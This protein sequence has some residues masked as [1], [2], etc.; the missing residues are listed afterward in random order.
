MQILLD[1]NDYL[2]S[3]YD[4]YRYHLVAKPCNACIITS[5]KQATMLQRYNAW[6]V[7]FMQFKKKKRYIFGHVQVG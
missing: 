5:K 3:K 2:I 1:K 4:T 6:W 7:K